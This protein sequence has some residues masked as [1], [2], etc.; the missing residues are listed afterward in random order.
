MKILIKSL[1]DALETVAFKDTDLNVVSIR[2]TLCTSI[3]LEMYE[4]FEQF[5]DCY[6]DIIVEAFDDIEKPRTGLVLPSMAQIR[7]I[8]EWS[9]GKDDFLIHCTAGISRSSAIAYLIKCMESSPETAVQI[10]DKKIH[11]PNLCVVRLGSE[12]L[13][14]RQ[15]YRTIKE[16]NRISES[17]VAKLLVESDIPRA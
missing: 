15:I 10:L 17:E 9:H 12:F 4:D 13:G 14:N 1:P 2:S 7:R 8:L 6:K 3:M 5:R 16:F 11:Y